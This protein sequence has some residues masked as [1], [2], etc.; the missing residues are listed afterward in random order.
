MG[1]GK[2][3]RAS[4]GWRALKG[5]QSLR[6]QEEREWPLDGNGMSRM[7]GTKIWGVWK[8]KGSCGKVSELYLESRWGLQGVGREVGMPG[9]WM[10]EHWASSALW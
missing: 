3:G 7:Q 4:W 2:L 9:E 5:Q 1:A 10:G 8:A 6:I